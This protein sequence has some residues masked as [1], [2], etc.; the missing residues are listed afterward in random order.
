MTFIHKC[1]TCKRS[2]GHEGESPAWVTAEGWMCGKHYELSE[3]CRS[4][5]ERRIVINNDNKL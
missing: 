1:I 3:T 4:R 5:E 2:L